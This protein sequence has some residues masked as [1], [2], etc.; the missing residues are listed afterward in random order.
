MF[1]IYQNN[2]LITQLHSQKRLY[3]AGGMP[4]TEAGID[5]G[6]FRDLYVSLGEP[7]DET[8][9]SVRLYYKPFIRWIWLGALF[10]A[11][12]GLLAATDRRYRMTL[13]SEQTQAVTA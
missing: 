6:L 13:K 3:N 11:A 2:Q 10:M 8:A 9:W 7:L 5:A 1:D 4:M 12:G